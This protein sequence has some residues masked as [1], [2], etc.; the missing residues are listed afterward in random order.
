MTKIIL[1]IAGEIAAGKGTT[2][3]YLIERYGAS[4]HRFSTAL[5]DVAR[6]MYLDESR[7]NLQ[8]ISTLMRE[9]FDD[10]ILS[11][12][13][14]KDVENDAHQVIAIDGVRRMADIEYLKKIP[15]FKLVYVETSMENRYERIVK[16][17]ENVDDNTKTFEGFKLDHE[18]EAELQVRE[19]KNHAD[20]VIDN[21]GTLKDLLLQVD[22]IVSQ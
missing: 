22:E 12:V 8:K 19:L 9:N 15:E 3:K 2:A 13:I 5:R 6:R 21:N 16:R 10:N 7:E 1:G 4:T 18:R 17:G 11:M 14:Y 20:F